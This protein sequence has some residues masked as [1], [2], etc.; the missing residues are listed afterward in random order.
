MDTTRY[1]LGVMLIVGIPPAVVY[2]LLIHP[3]VGF[4]R[5]IGPRGTVFLV[6]SACVVLGYFLFRWRHWVLGQDLGTSWILIAFGVVLY[7]LSAWISVLTK[8]QLSVRTFSGVPELA[9]EGSNDTLLKEGMYAVVRHPRYLSV[10]IGTAGFAMVI[11]YVGAYLMV[12]GTI[13]A[14]YL[15]AVLEERELED[16]FG[17]AYEDYRSRVPAILPRIQRSSA[18]GRSPRD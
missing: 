14:L 9:D 5:R 15:V 7:G 6:G 8:R 10:I 18:E 4:W 17:A 1:I 13:P 3:F 12:L 2:W 16:R 11:N